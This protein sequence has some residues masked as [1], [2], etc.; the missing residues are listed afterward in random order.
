MFKHHKHCVIEVTG[1]LTA[2][3][4]AS[5]ELQFYLLDNPIAPPLRQ[6]EASANIRTTEN[7]IRMSDQ[8][9]I[10]FVKQHASP[11]SNPVCR[12]QLKARITGNVN[13]DGGETHLTEVVAAVMVDGARTLNY[14]LAD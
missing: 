7:A 12:Y 4:D 1:I 14:A 10:A 2:I 6:S 13:M 9:L 8:A 3:E 5:G 11:N